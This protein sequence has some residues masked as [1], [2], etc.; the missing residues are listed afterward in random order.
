MGD[1]TNKSHL[2]L[3][4]PHKIQQAGLIFKKIL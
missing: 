3:R 1:K 2:S 4:I